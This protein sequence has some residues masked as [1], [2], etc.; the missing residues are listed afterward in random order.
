MNDKP[1]IHNWTEVKGAHGSVVYGMIYEDDRFI[2][3]EVVKTSLVRS[4]DRE[5]GVLTTNNTIYDLGMEEG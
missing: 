3:G 2:N 1:I 4:L 5:N